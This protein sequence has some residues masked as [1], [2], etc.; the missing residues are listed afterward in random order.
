MRRARLSKR[1]RFWVTVALALVLTGALVWRQSGPGEPE[2]DGRTLTEWLYPT[3]PD[4]EW[5]PN[6]LYGHIHD[7]F[8]AQLESGEPWTSP[9]APA[10]IA[11]PDGSPQRGALRSMGTNAFPWLL[12]WMAS[13]PRPTER[14]REFV[15]RKFALPL[16]HPG[17]LSPVERRHVAAFDGFAELGALAEP[18]LPALSN[19]LNQPNPDLPLAWA[20]ARTGPKGIAILTNA[21]THQRRDIRDLAALSLGLEGSAATSAVPALLTLIDR[22]EASYHVL[23][24]LGRIGCE[25]AR[26]APVLMRHLERIAS[27]DADDPFSMTVLLLGL[28]GDPARAA[29]PRLLALYE[30]ADPAER[31]SIR[32][33]LNRIEPSACARLPSDA[34][35]DSRGKAD[36]P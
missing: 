16:F 30:Q 25:P 11:S 9:K 10:E 14:L 1:R 34:G 17:G 23:G 20:I 12:D 18:A 7:E 13:R 36:V 8:L 22:G 24:A 3:E 2:Y 26:A 6:D 33:A 4:F 19:L 31:A 29:V 21:L 27:G 35:P 28:C 5:I 32:Q 15:H